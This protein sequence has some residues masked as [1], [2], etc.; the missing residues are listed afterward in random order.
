M[1]AAAVIGKILGVVGGVASAAG[2]YRNELARAHQLRFEAYQAANNAELARQDQIIVAESAAQERAAIAKASAQT[3]GATRTSF[4]AS[5]VV[6]DSGSAL[7]VDLQQAEQAAAEQARSRDEEAIA[8]HRLETERQGLLAESRLK[9][10]AS[11]SAKKSARLGAVGGV[12]QSVGGV[13]G[14]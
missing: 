4:A 12:L 3:R 2:T 11:K 5:N 9:R 8:K 13:M 6:V 1:A 14:R 7:E 10:K